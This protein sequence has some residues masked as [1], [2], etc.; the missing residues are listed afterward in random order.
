MPFVRLVFAVAW[1]FWGLWGCS[2]APEYHRPDPPT[3]TTALS[4]P[5]PIAQDLALPSLGDFFQE[6]RLKALIDLALTENRDLRLAALNVLAVRAEY[7]LAQAER[8]PSLEAE[9]QKIVQGGPERETTREYELGLMSV[10]EVDFFGRL[11]NLS[12]AAFQKYLGA[13]EAARAARLSLI[14]EV[15]EAYLEN[16]MSA[17][18][19]A[20][21]ER[22]LKSWR[23]SLAFI[24]NRLLS[25]QS[26]LLDL[27]QAR[28]QVARAELARATARTSLVRTEKNLKLLTGRLDD[29]A[30][31]SALTL[32]K[33][34]DPKLP[35]NVASNALLQRPDIL[36]AERDLIAS[37]FD[38]GAAR[39]AFF[40][41]LSLTGQFGYMS[42]QLNDLV[43]GA[44]AGW[45]FTP[46]LNLPLFTG[47]RNRRALELAEIRRSQSLA[48]YEKTIQAAFKEVAEA[49]EARP[50]LAQERLAQNR[51]LQ[52]QKRVLEL[53]ANR[54]QNGVI[55]YLE[56]LEAQRETFEAEMAALDIRRAQ[57]LNDIKLYLALG[58]GLEP[59]SDDSKTQKPNLGVTP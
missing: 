56:V 22:T 42:G 18:S 40:P 4:T 44:N 7:G 58:G 24:E 31:P 15:A 1:L 33:W 11:K 57:I 12:Q 35:E 39:A 36:A 55:S 34:P 30:L 10:F 9:A 47:G 53:A 27:E 59:N 29:P 37:H 49:L 14:A 50:K 6:P 8:Y 43:S 28:A 19:L 26:A 54:Y 5:E 23:D 45:S 16:R 51:L 25:G 3:P 2:L 41:S 38:I 32:A 17:E 48:T 21:T 46:R 13:A 52:T 20:L